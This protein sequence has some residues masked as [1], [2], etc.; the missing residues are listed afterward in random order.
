MVLYIICFDLSKPAEVQ[1]AQLT[2]WLEFLNSA[3]DINPPS[4]SAQSQTTTWNVMLVG[5]RADESTWQPGDDKPTSECTS[6]FQTWPSL[7][8][9]ERTFA[10]SSLTSTDSIKKL[11]E[12][13][14]K[15]CHRILDLHS[16][17]IPTSYRKVLDLI[18]QRFL[19]DTHTSIASVTELAQFCARDMTEQDFRQCLRYLHSIGCIVFLPHSDMVCADPSRIPKIAA[20]VWISTLKY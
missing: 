4:T 7:P 13:I 19:E 18:R 20:K 6:F 16:R 1:N 14:S 15:E 8:L 17:C 3:I 12:A 2:Y 10:V 11:I 9:H 5:L